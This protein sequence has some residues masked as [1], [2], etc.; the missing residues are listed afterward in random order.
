[1][2]T[3]I[4]PTLKLSEHADS[5]VTISGAWLVHALAKDKRIDDL[6]GKLQAFAQQPKLHWDLRDISA[7]DHVGALT[8]WRA[9]GKRR[10]AQLQLLQAHEGIFARLEEVGKLAVPAPPKPRLSGVMLLGSRVLAFFEHIQSFTALL[11]QL[12]LDLLRF[13]RHPLRGPWKELSAN[14][15]RMGAQALGIT[16]LVGILIGIV[17]S[18]LSAQQLRTFGG[19]LYIVNILGMSIIRELGPMLAAILVAG[20]SGSAITAQ[21]GVMRVTEELDA[22]SVMGIPH[23]FR[24]IMPKVLALAIAMPLLVIWTD[25]MAIAGGMISAQAL[26][27]M[28]PAF[29]LY[30]LP[31]AVPLINYW[32]GLLKGTSFGMLI[33]LVSCHYGLRIEPNTESLGRG[34]TNS[35]VVAIT[36]VII[37][38]AVY[39]II[40]SKLGY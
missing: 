24:L 16:A 8:L 19:D 25:I 4:L 27:G 30:K 36:V 23:G 21:L 29:F 37:A 7:L 14:L 5:T 3:D 34:T 11:G 15:Y 6:S 20:R 38:D 28:T 12:M 32:I 18:Y 35:V 26:L 1:M 10:P 31:E 17:L 2:H 9:W 13:A 39:A 40:F 33:A 22:M